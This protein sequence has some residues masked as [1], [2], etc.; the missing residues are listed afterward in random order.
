MNRKYFIISL[1][2]ILAA[3]AIGWGT[4]QFIEN[5]DKFIGVVQAIPVVR[6]EHFDKSRNALLLGLFN[7]GNLPMEIDRTELIYQLN[8]NDLQFITNVREYGDKPLVLDPGDTIL[9]PLKKN[10]FTGLQTESG[11]FWGNLEFRVPGTE[12]IYNLHHKVHIFAF[13][14][15]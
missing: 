2:S 12:D 4:A 5:Q 1:C 14:K 15:D 10:A 11:S 3:F 6:F 9:V 13:D 8:T 7:P